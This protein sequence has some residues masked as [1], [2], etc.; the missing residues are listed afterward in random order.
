MVFA[1]AIEIQLCRKAR[2]RRAA[3]YNTI[4]TTRYHS[5]ITLKLIFKDCFDDDG[6]FSRPNGYVSL[7]LAGNMSRKQIL[8]H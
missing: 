6:L 4:Y 7:V 8:S 5:I 3:W 1:L 2:K